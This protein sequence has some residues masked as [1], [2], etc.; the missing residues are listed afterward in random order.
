MRCV[1][2]FGLEEFMSNSVSTVFQINQSIRP[3][4]AEDFNFPLHN[5]KEIQSLD[6]KIKSDPGLREQLARYS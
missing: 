1:S 6:E 2:S 4:N 3:A 5:V